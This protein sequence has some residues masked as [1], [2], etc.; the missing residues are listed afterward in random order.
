MKKFLIFALAWLIAISDPLYAQTIPGGGGG[1]GGGLNQLTGDVT[2]GPG[3]GSQAATLA[4]V[5]SS[6]GTYGSA[7]QA[8]QIVVN[9]KGLATAVSNLTITPALASITGLGSGV[10]TALAI[11]HDTTGGICTVGGSGCPG[12]GSGTVTS[13]ATGAGLTGGTI[14]TSGTIS[15]TWAIN[16]Q[17]GTTY[18]ILSSDAAKLVTFN[19]ASAVAVTLPQ[20]TGSFA[21]GFAFDVQDIGAG[22][23]TITPT[24]STINGASTLV[25]PQNYGCSIVSDGTNYQ[26][27]ACLPVAGFTGSGNI[28]RATS[29]TLVTPALGTIASGNLASGTG[30]TVANLAGAGTG[31]LTAL[32]TNVS[33]TGAICLASGSSCAVGVVNTVVGSGSA[34]LTGP[35]EIYIC[36]TTCSITP[37]VP[38]AGMQFCVENDA[39]VSTVITMVG[40]TGVF[41]QK[42]VAPGTANGYGSSGGTMTSGGAVGDMVC[43]IGRDSTHYLVGAYGGTFTN[44]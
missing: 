34:S 40:N 22:T 15:S 31:V 18:T 43:L 21:A 32:G 17:T 36:T 42:A 13:V 14:T 28:V 16:A 10:P 33:G 39:A 19:N 37:P 26:V 41:Y 38:A 5:N 9:A 1:G 30:Y 4:T 11:T 23:A 3:T 27:S 8:P 25:I 7:T 29:P 2:A 12:G 24:T 44:S 35:S 20:A 6:P